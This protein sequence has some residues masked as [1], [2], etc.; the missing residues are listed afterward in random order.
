MEKKANRPILLRR[1]YRVSTIVAICFF[2]ILIFQ[3]LILVMNFVLFR[4][5]EKLNKNTYSFILQR[6]DQSSKEIERAMVNLWSNENYI[7][8]V[9]R[10]MYDNY[11]E[12]KNQGEVPQFNAQIGELL[13]NTMNTMKVSGAFAIYTPTFDDQN[14]HHVLHFKDMHHNM[15]FSHKTDLIMQTGDSEIANHLGTPLATEWKPFLKD[16]DHTLYQRILSHAQNF[17]DLDGHRGFWLSPDR[18]STFEDRYIHYIHLLVDPITHEVYG[19]IGVEINLFMINDIFHYSNIS[20]SGN[21]GFILVSSLNE[22]DNHSKWDIITAKGPSLQREIVNFSIDAEK[23]YNPYYD[24]QHKVKDNSSIYTLK[25]IHGSELVAI[26][27][28]IRLSSIDLEKYTKVWYLM[29]VVEKNDIESY[30]QNLIRSF[31]QLLLLSLLMGIAVIS[32]VTRIIAYPIYQLT[33]NVKRLMNNGAIFRID[34]LNIRE[35]DELTEVIEDLSTKLLRN[36]KKFRKIIETVE[37]PFVAVEINYGDNA[38]YKL[39]RLSKILP[40]CIPDEKDETTLD[41]EYYEQWIKSFY[42]DCEMVESYYDHEAQSRIEVI[43]KNWQG[44]VYY[45][46]V[47]SK[48]VENYELHD[49]PTASASF[50]DKKPVLL[51]ILMD[52][53]KEMQ[54]KIKI[55]NERDLDSLT[56]LLNHFSFQESVTEYLSKDSDASSTA[57][58]IMWDLDNLKYV[59]DTYGH[60]QG[61]RYLK[62]AG[63][64]IAEFAREGA[65]VARVSGDEFFVFFP[66]SGEKNRIRRKISR[67]HNNLFSNVL[68]I[69]E[70]TKIKLRATAGITWYPSD[71]TDFLELKKYADFAM[72]TAKH[73]S[74]GSV[75]EFSRELFE[76]N[77]ILFSGKEDLHQFIE[78][79]QIRFAFQPIVSAQT[80]EVFGYEALMRS[81]SPQ[82]NSV[83]DILRLAKAQS[84]LLDIETLTFEGALS[85]YDRSLDRFGDKYLFVN[86]IPNVALTQKTREA[87][88]S[89]YGKYFSKI[90]I[91]II[92]SEMVD[93][94]SMKIKKEVHRKYGCKIAIDDYGTGY[95]TESQL[96]LVSPDFI[97]VDMA[98]IRNIHKDNERQT[99]V[100]NILRYT[101]VR[102]IKVIAEGVENSDELAVLIEMGVDYVQGFYLGIPSFDIEDI[103]KNKKSEILHFNKIRNWKQ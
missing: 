45:L 21:G 42:A 46:K 17:N 51:Q 77:Y 30:A 32:V 84:R 59:N 88:F 43:K 82:M 8:P 100:A 44:K 97:K 27:R 86:S 63:S 66:Y 94:E 22:S 12:S 49:Y 37:V 60:D 62:L 91:E 99:I 90:V 92:E 6:A 55:K 75:C 57:A 73:S 52:R 7:E 16:L 89:K 34:P 70:T 81:T 29:A 98:L 13:L 26:Q 28:P 54:D 39:G 101:K 4:T 47:I 5:D 14:I 25:N 38:V 20:D 53:T 36:S 56:G 83:L 79:K 35:I 18:G 50:L 64:C 103:D 24:D 23:K 33:A 93:E 41:I 19:I 9:E 10:R 85:E 80:G 87:L 31:F 71:S 40:N 15:L 58:M 1:K 48:T 3:S 61:D 95:A 67:I 69:S 11:L 96:L 102:N 68:E 76:K 2:S 65:Y 74:K 72:Y 78:E